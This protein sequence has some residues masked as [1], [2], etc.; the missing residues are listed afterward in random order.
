MYM[1]T[2]SQP[3]TWGATG[4]AVWADDSGH[5]Y[6]PTRGASREDIQTGLNW[7]ISGHNVSDW[8]EAWY[9][10]VNNNDPNLARDLQAAVMLDVGRDGVP[11]VAAVDTYDLPNW[12]K[13]SAA[14]HTR[15]AV[16]IVGYDNTANPPTYTYID[17]CG[18]A[19]DPRPSNQNG[20][21]HVIAQSKMVASM[22]DDVGVGFSW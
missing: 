9:G 6:Y 5:A 10:A 19:C 11:V 15:H 3:P 21:V 14:P 12:Q 16:S 1:A 13:G 8:T 7:E 4:I 18:K 17:T 22:I 2:K 20:Q